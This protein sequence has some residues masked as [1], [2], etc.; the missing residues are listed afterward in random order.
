MRIMSGARTA[1]AVITGDSIA[2]RGKMNRIDY[3]T[4]FGVPKKIRIEK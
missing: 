3:Y 4:T 2:L 1:K